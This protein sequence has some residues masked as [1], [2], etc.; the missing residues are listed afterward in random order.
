M[1]RSNQNK[2]DAENVNDAINGQVRNQFDELREIVSGQESNMKTEIE[3]LIQLTEK[4][5]SDR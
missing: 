3:K 4:S 1:Q 5:E 2:F